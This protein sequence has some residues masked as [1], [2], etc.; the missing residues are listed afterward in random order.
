MAARGRA[1]PRVRYLPSRCAKC[2]FSSA[3]PSPGEKRPEK[4][5]VKTGQGSAGAAWGPRAAASVAPYFYACILLSVPA[6]P[7][8]GSSEL[9][10]QKSWRFRFYNVTRYK[11]RRC[12]GIFNHYANASGKGKPEFY[13]RVRPSKGRRP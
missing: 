3:P 9:G 6:C 2:L 5:G 11:C 7:H 12:G 4:A 13:I 10:V 1:H 8:C